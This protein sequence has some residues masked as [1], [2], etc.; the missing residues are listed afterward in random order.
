M[1]IGAGQEY[2]GIG[3]AFEDQCVVL[4]IAQLVL[5]GDAY[6]PGAVANPQPFDIACGGLEMPGNRGLA[7][8]ANIRVAGGVTVIFGI[9][10][11]AC[12]VGLAMDD[13]RWRDVCEDRI[14]A[15]AQGQHQKKE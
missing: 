5:Q 10:G 11:D 3:V 4:F 13:E 14:G 9:D 8:G 6:P 1:T 7:D 15:G 12:L 2:A